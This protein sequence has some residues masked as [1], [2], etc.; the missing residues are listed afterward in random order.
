MTTTSSS[1]CSYCKCTIFDSG[2]SPSFAYLGC[3]RQKMCIKCVINQYKNDNYCPFCKTSIETKI[4]KLTKTKHSN[5]SPESR[6]AEAHA[7]LAN[8][9]P[10]NISAIPEYSKLPECVLADMEACL[11]EAVA[12]EGALRKGDD[13]EE[14][15]SIRDG[16]KYLTKWR[17]TKITYSKIL[18]KEIQKLGKLT[19]V[20][21]GF[22]I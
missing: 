5:T 22:S 16:L 14:S 20:K 11:W 13:I 17:Q 4:S 7:I 15:I 9:E 1:N 19:T 21:T 18:N 6:I 12:Y 2:I 8:L 3:C 10:Y